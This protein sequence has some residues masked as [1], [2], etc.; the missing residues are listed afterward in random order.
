MIQPQTA[1]EQLMYTTMRIEADLGTQGTSY[2]TAFRFNFKLDDEHEIPA[3]VT[4]KHVVKGATRGKF[5]VHLADQNDP[6][7]V[8]D[9]SED[10]NFENFEQSFFMHPDPD[11]DLCATPL[12]PLLNAVT[13][14]TQ[15][16]KVFLTGFNESLIPSQEVLEGLSTVENILMI[17]Y[18]NALWDEVN[19]LPLFR[20]GITSS[21][22]AIDYGGKSITVIDAACFPGS[23]GSP[24]VLHDSGMYMDK[25]GNTRVGASRLLLLG[26][27]FAGPQVTAEGSIQIVDIPTKQTPIAVTPM[28]MHLGYIVKAK[29]IVT[30]GKTV[31]DELQRR[32]LLTLPIPV[33][34]SADIS[35][36]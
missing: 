28:M 25:Q 35:N 13:A 20:K 18:P 5:R 6:L 29:E 17:G 27:L 11:V 1:T 15:G 36:Q 33:P 3:I 2:G 34:A 14:G 21:H 32:G 4:N 30:L 9:E 16:R 22:P 26:V 12:Q 31:I 8:S 19:N 7:L 10:I 24:V 23:S